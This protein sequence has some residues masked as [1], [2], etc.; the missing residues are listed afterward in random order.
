MKVLVTAASGMLGSSLCPMLAENGHIVVALSHSDL[1]VCDTRAVIEAITSVRPDVVVHLAA[2][3]DVDYCEMYPDVAFRVNAV[4][5]WNVAVACGE[6]DA[7]LFYISTDGVYEG[8]KREPYNEYDPTG[9]LSAYSKA[10]LAGEQHVKDHLSRYFILRAGWMFGG[11]TKDRKFV[12]KILARARQ[13]HVITAVIDKVGSPIYTVDLSQV[14]LRL[15]AYPLYGTYNVSNSG[16]CSRYEFA[17]KIIEYAGIDC[18][19]KP[20]TSD[21]FDLPAPRPAM[22]MIRNYRLQLAGLPDLRPWE[23]ALQEYIGVLIR[24]DPLFPPD[25]L[26]RK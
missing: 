15:M 21:A 2:L 12:A 5:T 25:S 24:K 20:V 13:E 26:E 4:G 14:I 22:S 3:T 16:W 18:E 23:E 7:L 1:D 17:R 9:P 11:Q 8:T 6:V 10:K 19:V